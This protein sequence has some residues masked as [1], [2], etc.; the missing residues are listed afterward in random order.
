MCTITLLTSVGDVVL[1]LV[2][3]LGV[4]SSMGMCIS[5]MCSVSNM[6]WLCNDSDKL[7]A[8]PVVVQYNGRQT[9]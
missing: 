5:M 9:V 6:P 1:V 3:L 7:S 8:I 4:R 2:L